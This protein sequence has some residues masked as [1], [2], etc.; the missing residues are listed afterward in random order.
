[1]LLGR[2]SFLLGRRQTVP[3]AELMA[4]IALLKVTIGDLRLCTDSVV[5][6]QIKKVQVVGPVVTRMHGVSFGMS[7]KIEQ[8]NS[9]CP[10]SRIKTNQH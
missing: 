6:F 1:M 3:R 10:G 4:I 9:A 8:L 7:L 5:T 2:T